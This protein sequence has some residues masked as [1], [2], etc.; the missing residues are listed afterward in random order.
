VTA[1][2]PPDLGGRRRPGGVAGAPAATY[3]FTVKDFTSS[4]S[5][6]LPA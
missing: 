2:T 6:L 3:P 5:E 1:T 4:A